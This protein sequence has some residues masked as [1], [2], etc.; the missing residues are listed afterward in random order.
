MGQGPTRLTALL[1]P[2]LLKPATRAAARPDP[3]I[4]YTSGMAV[5]C[6]CLI[7]FSVWSSRPAWRHVAACDSTIILVPTA[8]R[9][10]L[11]AA[12]GGAALWAAA[13]LGTEVK[14][15]VS[16]GGRPDLALPVLPSVTCP[17]LLLV[18]SEDHAV[19]DMNRWEAG[20]GWSS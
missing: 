5:Q 8:P 2:M 15:V 14:A 19:V 11:S 6:T 17:V 9:A 4:K 20:A 12:G 13:E 18:G 16:R 1:V 10:C 7:C 3:A